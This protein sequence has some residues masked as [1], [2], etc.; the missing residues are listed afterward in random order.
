MAD[1]NKHILRRIA[2]E[3]VNGRNLAV[4]DTLFGRDYV[5]HGL[6]QTVDEVSL[7][8]QLG[9]TELPAAAHT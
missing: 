1:S 9:V 6:W 2:D 8:R 5:L 3:I 7:L 4:A